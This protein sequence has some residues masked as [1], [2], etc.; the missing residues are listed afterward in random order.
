LRD[1]SASE[2]ATEAADLTPTADRPSSPPVVPDWLA[3]SAG[4]GWRLLAV[5]A[6][7]LVVLAAAAVLGTV[8]ASVVLAAAVTAAFD[9]LTA[10]LQA[11]GRSS[12][13][14]AGLVML[15]AIG[16]GLAAAAAATVAFV[17]ALLDLLQRVEEGVQELET[18]AGLATIPAPLAD[19]LTEMAGGLSDWASSLLAS[20]IGSVASLATVVLLAV[21]LLF[22]LVT[23]ADR[24]I[25]WS[26]QAVGSEQ[27]TQIETAVTVARQRLGRFL[28]ETAYRA[29]VICLVTLVVALV[30]GLP[31]PLALAT[32]VFIGGF[33]PLLGLVAATAAVGL[34]ALGAVGG[35]PA[36]IAVVVIA[37]AT[38]L[39]PRVLRPGRWE[40]HGLHPAIVL[41]ALTVGGV[42]AGGLGLILAIP[43]AIV[44]AEVVP[45]VVAAL[46]GGPRPAEADGALG[47][48]PR[49]LDRLA[50]WSWRLL[51]LVG[52]AAVAGGL[53][54]QVPLF[55]GPLIIAGVLAATL[56]PGVGVLR[57][58]GVTPTGASLAMTVG[59]FGLVLAVL[60][61]TLAA[62]AGPMEDIITNAS[63]GASLVDAAAS[64]GA[65]IS[66]IV[67]E[68]GPALVEAARVLAAVVVGFVI[69]IVLG[70]ILTFYLLRDGSRGFEAATARLAS[71]RREELG[72][73]GARVT[74]VV[75]GYMIGTGAISAFGAATQFAIMAI[76][77]IPLAWPLAV[78]AFFGGFIPYI[79][80]LLTT[81]LAFL[82]TVATGDATDILVMGIFTIVFNI[83]QGN[84]VAPLVYGRAVSIHPAVVLLAI[85][86]GSAIAGIAGMFL[87]VPV[88]GVIATTW[89]TVLRVFGTEPA[90]RAGEAAAGETGAAGP[91]GAA[92]P[93]GPPADRPPAGPA[94]ASS[95]SA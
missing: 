24:A 68:V 54:L 81:G 10:R 7:S 4:L 46:N 22:F 93:A 12:T 51:V 86:A 26:L 6:F 29:F 75:G 25:A 28:R 55:I 61:L 34:V 77:G 82:V 31:A 45:A 19:L 32:L 35:V 2:P 69:G 15:A 49:W 11:S 58:R 43:V 67:A 41:V 17:P 88:L 87:A 8:V 13:K 66:S 76:L 37:A 53:L 9:P 80:S 47:I 33:V 62:L 64:S 95:A 18:L 70:A 78:L 39:L 3:H 44:I 79:G 84:I 48:V 72:E 90:D 71:W 20:A 36:F 52:V 89:R 94:A 1:A 23:D 74:S 38:V 59:G 16:I 5:G 50:Q 73:A 21:F 40:G 42:V 63:L 57:Q 83:V 65:T 85:P 91:G 14:V 30:L 56:A 92:E 60:L 27:R